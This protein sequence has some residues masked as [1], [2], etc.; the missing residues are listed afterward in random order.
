VAAIRLTAEQCEA[1]YVGRSDLWIEGFT[2]CRARVTIRVM[3]AWYREW[4]Q[5]REAV[6]Y[7]DYFPKHV[8]MKLNHMRKRGQT[9]MLHWELTAFAKCI[10]RKERREQYYAGMAHTR[11][12]RAVHKVMHGGRKDL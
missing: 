7:Y 4:Q 11:A 1:L 8:I 6:P 12:K 9:H 5:N 2:L 10:D 3:E